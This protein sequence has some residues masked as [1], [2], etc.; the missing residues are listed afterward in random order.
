MDRR[1]T[2]QGQ[3]ARI[4]ER[5]DGTKTLIGTGAVFYREGNDGTEYR[6]GANVKERIAETAFDKALERQDDARG[7]FNHEPDNLLGRVSS[8]TMRLFKRDD[9]LGYEIDLPDT[10][11]G[12]DVAESIKRGDLTGSS[13]AFTVDESDWIRADGMDVREIRSVSLFDTGPVTYPA[14]EGTT[15]GI[16]AEGDAEEAIKE[17]E[18]I[19]QERRERVG[20]AKAAMARAKLDT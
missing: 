10:Q 8:G 14:Y 11:V 19:K 5:D 12:R 18:A 2:T 17:L 9:G 6:I 16:R 13:F 3:K 1:F 7:L 20:R 15:T 4:E